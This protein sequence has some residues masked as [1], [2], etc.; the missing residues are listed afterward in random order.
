MS[1]M[2]NEER[3]TVKFKKTFT[4]KG[5]YIRVAVKATNSTRTEEMCNK[6]AAA[7]S[8][9]QPVNERGYLALRSIGM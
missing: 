3:Y 6:S 8:T 1:V 2:M 5:G 9:Q 4:N 7:N